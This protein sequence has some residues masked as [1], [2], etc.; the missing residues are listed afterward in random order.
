[1]FIFED[2]RKRNNNYSTN[3]IYDS[4]LEYNTLNYLFNLIIY[5][6][7]NNYTS[8]IIKTIIDMFDYKEK[9]NNII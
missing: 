7:C 9:V 5:L 4:L 8:E 1:M 2:N 3:N 6:D